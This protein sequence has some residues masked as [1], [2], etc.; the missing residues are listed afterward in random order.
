MRYN[1]TESGIKIVI[2]YISE[3]NAKRKEILDSGKDTADETTIP[4]PEDILADI[5]FIGLDKEGCY[6]NNWGVT[7]NYDADY[8]ISLKYGIDF[9]ENE[10]E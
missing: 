6:Y 1:L 9:V 2:S 5:D 10:K 4:T 7:D 8:P 3:L